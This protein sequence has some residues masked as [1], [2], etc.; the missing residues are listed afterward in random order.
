[1][2][3]R[4][5]KKIQHDRGIT[6]RVRRLLRARCVLG[7]LLGIVSA[8]AAALP[9]ALTDPTDTLESHLGPAYYGEVRGGVRVSS[10]G[11]AIYEIPI[12]VPPGTA[13]MTPALSLL[14]NSNLDNGLVGLGWFL[15]G[16][17]SRVTRCDKTF[18]Q[19]GIVHRVNYTVTDRFCLDGQRLV[20]AS[21]TY[22]GNG[23][24]Y[25]KAIDDF[26]RIR[27]A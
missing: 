16:T 15:R 3:G 4:P 9:P 5:D 6:M 17:T 12:A 13:G 2:V 23:A 8:A 11:S 21:G 14:Y 25:R 20:L 26:S 18:V 1:M 7:V 24:E 10:A 22:G 27:S 19:D